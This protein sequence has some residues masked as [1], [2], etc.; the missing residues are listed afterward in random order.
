M[1]THAKLAADLLRNAATFFRDVAGQNPDLTD[2]M[3][4]NAGTFDTIAKLVEDDP[5]GELPM[6]GENEPSENE[7]AEDTS[8]G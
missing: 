2:Q 8:E 1:A 6:P 3:L 4:A 7:P 5:T